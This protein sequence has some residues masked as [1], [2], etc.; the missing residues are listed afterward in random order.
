MKTA[1]KIRLY[2]LLILGALT[3]VSLLSSCQKKLDTELSAS[4]GML[5]F[6]V[7]DTPQWQAGNVA[8]SKAEPIDSASL[9][10]QKIGDV[11]EDGQQ[12]YLHTS[13]EP[14]GTIPQNVEVDTKGTV[15]N[16]GKFFNTFGLL[17]MAYTGSSYNGFT[18]TFIYNAKATGG[19]GNAEV[20]DVTSNT[21]F[22]TTNK[23][24]IPYG[25]NVALFAYAPYK[26]ASNDSTWIT[27]PAA[28]TSW[29]AG[30]PQYN[31]EV[32]PYLKD[33]KD[34]CFAEAFA[35]SGSSGSTQLNF[36]HA[37]SAVRFDIAST[38]PACT[39]KS[40][41]LKNVRYKGTVTPNATN[42]EGGWWAATNETKDFSYNNGGSGIPHRGTGQTNVFGNGKAFFMIPQSAT[43]ITLELVVQVGS[44]TERTLRQTLTGSWVK[45]NRYNYT[46]SFTPEDP[47][48][49]E[50][51]TTNG[52]GV[53]WTTSN[54]EKIGTVSEPGGTY[55]FNVNSQKGTAKRAYK[56]QYRTSTSGDWTDL[57]E[58]SNT[59][60]IGQSTSS[61]DFTGG[62]GTHTFKVYQQY[63]IN[64]KQTSDLK[65]KAESGSTRLPTALDRSGGGVTSSNC[66]VVSAPGYYSFATNY[67]NAIVANNPMDNSTL[68]RYKDYNGN[69]ISNY[70][71]NGSTARVLWTDVPNLITNVSVSGRQLTFQVPR[72]TIQEGNGVIGL[73]DGSG[74]CM[75]SWHI[76]V[77]PDALS[78]VAIKNIGSGQT[79]QVLTRP[80]GYV[81][82]GTASW[83]QG[84]LYVRFVQS[85]GS[86]GWNTSNA[87]QFTI[88][89]TGAQNV[90]TPGRYPVYQWGRKDPLWPIAATKA[91]VAQDAPVYPGPAGNTAYLPSLQQIQGDNGGNPS[92][93]N[94]IRNPHR[95]Y[96][97]RVSESLINSTSMWDASPNTDGAWENNYN[98]VKSIYDP[99]PIGFKVAP[100]GTFD[101]FSHNGDTYYGGIATPVNPTKPS[102][103]YG[104]G[105]KYALNYTVID[106][107][108]KIVY[109]LL[110]GSA[111]TYAVPLLGA[112]AALESWAASRVSTNFF[113]WQTSRVKAPGHLYACSFGLFATEYDCWVDLFGLGQMAEF[114]QQ[115]TANAFPI[116]PVAQ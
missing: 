47:T 105:K 5:R 64:S 11:W 85:D 22:Q 81:N 41:T 4:D 30:R 69:F 108:S 100:P 54:N 2:D 16:Q 111:A 76:W 103:G 7:S 88:K 99:S 10:V 21:V 72:E 87:K 74:V 58:N 37:M 57:P 75:W 68:S 39:V 36:M 90:S 31:V 92:I 106:A 56:V 1:K 46:L 23:F 50:V 79:Q 109:C 20:I 49:F 80:I 25:K 70:Y 12:M 14:L 28:T 18:P 59:L 17:G 29:S 82:A 48:T 13:V 32:P 60:L 96:G 104:Q 84:T 65:G 42:T 95:P 97:M 19:G 26:D 83:R 9:K 40:I 44:G 67:G 115:E 71:M 73:F 61:T 66:Y 110:S 45:G 78:T 55:T 33:Q 94:M 62:N 3:S 24:Y 52:G 34:I 91:G 27:V 89:Q 43:S 98:T 63:T 53:T 6:E 51:T 15:I 116:I 8:A 93:K 35:S 77:T 38:V 113:T 86:N 102:G 112:R 107:N 114:D 101:A